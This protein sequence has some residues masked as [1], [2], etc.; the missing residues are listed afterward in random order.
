MNTSNHILFEPNH[1]EAIQLL[2]KETNC[3]V[4]EVSEVYAETLENI[5]SHARIQDYLII[6]THKKVRDVLYQIK[7]PIS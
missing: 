2:T 5:R 4:K 3:S 1:V 6:L 7:G